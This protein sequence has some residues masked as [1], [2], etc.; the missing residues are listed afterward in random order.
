MRGLH[1]AGLMLAG[2]LAL[3]CGNAVVVPEDAAAATGSGAS[4]GGGDASCYTAECVR[5]PV[6][7]PECNDG[8]VGYGCNAITVVPVACYYRSQNCTNCSDWC[9]PEGGATLPAYA[10]SAVAAPAGIP[11]AGCTVVPEVNW[12]CAA[13]LKPVRA[14]YCDPEPSFIDTGCIDSAYDDTDT[15]T[16]DGDGA[17]PLFCCP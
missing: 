11:P 3:S 7:D 13:Q 6:L 10:P 1:L 17:P 15:C 12:L 4:G 5:F 14:A 2:A 16:T 9:C 8:Y